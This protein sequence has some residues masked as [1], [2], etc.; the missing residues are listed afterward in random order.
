MYMII[1]MLC[2]GAPNDDVSNFTNDVV[3]VTN[4]AANATTPGKNPERNNKTPAIIAGS[5]SFLL[6]V[7]LF[8]GY[9]ALFKIF[10]S[11]M[12]HYAETFVCQE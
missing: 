6:I 10:P 4:N 11:A 5:S 7:F 9:R 3:D 2:C 8:I 1:I 12:D